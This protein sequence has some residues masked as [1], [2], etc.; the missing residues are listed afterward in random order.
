MAT[1]TP[2]PVYNTTDGP[3]LID[4]DGRALGGRE[5]GEADVKT[6]PA[7]RHV[8][9]GRLIQTDTIKPGPAPVKEA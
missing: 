5:H 6:N 7:K 4:A 8:S 1:P 3:L 2:V 9:A